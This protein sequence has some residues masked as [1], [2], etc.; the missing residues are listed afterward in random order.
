MDSHPATAPNPHLPATQSTRKRPR[1]ASR[2]DST[3][4]RIIKRARR[5]PVARKQTFHTFSTDLRSVV[6]QLIVLTVK[7]E[8]EYTPLTHPDE[9]RLL[10]VNPARN[11]NDPVFC[12]LIH[13]F[14]IPD[15]PIRYEAL[16]YT[17]GTD[18]TVNE[19]KIFNRK[20]L[21][22]QNNGAHKKLWAK[23]YV[24][25]NLHAAL[26]HLRL[27][28]KKVVLWADALCINQANQ[29][30]RSTQVIKMIDIYSRAT[31]VLVW[32]GTNSIKS[33]MALEFIPTMLGGDTLDDLLEDDENCDCWLA[34]ADL[35]RNEWFSRRWVVQ[36]LAMAKEASIH[37]GSETIHWDDFADAVA[38]FAKHHEKV[39]E[40]I[41]ASQQTKN[42][43][44]HGTIDP[45]GNV[46][47]G[48]CMLVETL[49]NLFRKTHDGHIERLS[50]LE[51]LV[52]TLLTFKSSEPHDTIY[53]VLSLAK[54]TAGVTNGSTNHPI[55]D[56]L[57]PNYE[58]PLVD[59][60]KDF[61]DFC[62]SSSESLDIIC[63]HWAP[64]PVKKRPTIQE[65][66]RG[67]KPIANEKLPSW[68]P[69]VS[70]SAYG[71]P[72]ESLTGRVNGDSLVGSP[73]RKPYNA[74]PKTVAIWRFGET[75]EIQPTADSST[76]TPI[77][78]TSP[79]LHPT[80]F[81]HSHLTKQVDKNAV[82]VTSSN[83]NSVYQYPPPSPLR[84]GPDVATPPIASWRPPTE[85][86]MMRSNGRMFVKGFRLDTIA[87]LGSR[88]AQ[89]VIPRECLEMGG[90]ES[91]ADEHAAVDDIRDELW[92]TLVADRGPNGE[93]APRWYKRACQHCIAQS[94]RGDIDIGKLI[95]TG[96]PR[97]MVEFLRR[98]RAVIWNRKFLRSAAEPPGPGCLA[99]RR[100]FG[101]AP[102]RAKPRDVICIL[103]GC[104]VPVILREH[105]VPSH[106][107]EFIGEA[108][109]YGMMDGEALGGRK[110]EE[111]R[112]TCEEFELM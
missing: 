12:E 109:L 54:D 91:G 45:L 47:T 67:I 10:V 31:N 57:R 19:I 56:R 112:E 65:K 105:S 39:G 21:G 3:D 89:G 77:T 103:L 14:N 85:K 32:L 44:Q 93:N 69:L 34:L 62:V 33:K 5:T 22:R 96:K 7:N 49:N 86:K 87:E 79:A 107:F 13:S 84:S 76:N 17:W 51:T 72:E 4:H 9:I 1:T 73:Q 35:M 11:K 53:A 60:C 111:L 23:F 38:L 6:N 83:G 97:A 40:L 88:V 90:F 92:R 52:S 110:M 66:I 106:Y 15:P 70:R 50:T 101:L 48:A 55:L 24:K 75:E 80:D 82:D 58:K 46:Q 74:S 95:E 29:T 61:I 28:D 100:L 64:T 43:L 108:Y 26:R 63:R 99:P 30:E 104:S 27:P 25:S 20:Q 36:E 37:C 42:A 59:V 16:S 18:D 81:V 78:A 71:T 94:T 98:V 8:Y 68:I 2:A 41:G 102:D